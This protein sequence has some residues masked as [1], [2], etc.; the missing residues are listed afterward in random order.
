M[1]SVFRQL[2]QLNGEE[3]NNKASRP[4]KEFT[5]PR[6]PLRVT[7]SEEEDESEEEEDEPDH[8][9]PAGDKQDALKEVGVSSIFDLWLHY[10]EF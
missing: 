6:E 5:P 2:E 7:H 3:R 4:L 8:L 1:L 10:V 9:S